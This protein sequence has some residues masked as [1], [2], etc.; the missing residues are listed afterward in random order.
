MQINDARRFWI[1]LFL[2]HALCLVVWQN[3]FEDKDDNHNIILNAILVDESLWIW[4]A[5]FGLPTINNNVLHMSTFNLNFIKGEDLNV[6]FWFKAIQIHK[7]IYLWM[8]MF[9]AWTIHE[10]EMTRLCRD[11]RGV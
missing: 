7:T 5:F 11:V 2:L 10:L 6:N 8:V 1:C 4:H 9:C 3:N